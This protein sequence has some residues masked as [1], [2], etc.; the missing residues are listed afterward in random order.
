MRIEIDSRPIANT[1]LL[2]H[3]N[4]SAEEEP[5]TQSI[6]TVLPW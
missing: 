2:Q 1:G 6:V 5:W 3:R 4:T